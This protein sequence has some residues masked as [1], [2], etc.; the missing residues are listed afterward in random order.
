MEKYLWSY[1]GV[2]LKI[3]QKIAHKFPKS[4]LPV[5][6]KLAEKYKSR[7]DEEIKERIKPEIEKIENSELRPY[8]KRLM[9]NAIAPTA[10]I[11]DDRVHVPLIL[12][13]YNVPI[14]D[15]IIHDDNFSVSYDLKQF[16]MTFFNN[17]R[18]I[19]GRTGFEDY[20]ETEMTGAIVL[21]N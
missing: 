7:T 11:Y 5:R 12:S 13:G 21:K 3:G 9:K 6:K 8:E 16:D 18:T 4:M 14:I 17:H 15:E 2:G 1:S 10:H 20:E 19:H